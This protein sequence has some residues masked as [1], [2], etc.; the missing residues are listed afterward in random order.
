MKT[1]RTLLILMLIVNL[2]SAQQSEKT[3]PVNDK[4]AMG[5]LKYD[6]TTTGRHNG[7]VSVDRVLK[8][9]AKKQQMESGL[10]KDTV[11]AYIIYFFRPIEHKLKNYQISLISDDDYNKATYSWMTDTIVS[12]TLIN[13]ATNKKRNLKLAQTTCKGCSAG[14]LKDSF[15]DADEKK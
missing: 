10:K 9:W 1:Y 7:D 15:E 5:V 4:R 6:S 13:T 8:L 2:V 3:I 11:Q 12:V 14:I